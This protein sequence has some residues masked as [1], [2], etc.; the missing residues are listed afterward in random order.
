MKSISN[1]VQSNHLNIDCLLKK[2]NKYQTVYLSNIE[3]NINH[4]FPIEK[5]EDLYTYSYI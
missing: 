1:V 5:E 3:C 4:I 2:S